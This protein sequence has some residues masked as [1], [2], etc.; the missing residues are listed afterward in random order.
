MMG[1]QALVSVA[2]NDHSVF[3]IEGP[4][5]NPY[6]FGNPVEGNL[7]LGREDVMR[8]LEE[9]LS[10]ARQSS[11]VIL[12]GHRRMGKS[13][14]LRNLGGRFGP[15][16]IIVDFNMQRVG[17]V[18]NTNELL[19]GLALKFYDA[20]CDSGHH[21]LAEPTEALFYDHNPYLAFDRFLGVL[22]RVRDRH[23]FIVTVDEFELIEQQINEQRV[24]MNLLAHWRGI[25]QTYPWLIMIFAGLHAL[26]EM[27][28]DYWSPL[29]GSVTAV[30]VSF[31][32]Y[33]AAWRLITQPAADFAIDYD[34]DV[35]DQIIALTNGQPYLVQ[36]I[37]HNL[38]TSFNRHLYEEGV[39]RDRRFTIHDLVA[40]INAPEFYR[41]GNAYFS[42]VWIQAATSQPNGQ[43]TVLQSLSDGPLSLTEIAIATGMSFDLVRA[44]L[45]TLQHHDVIVQRD[46][47]HSYAVELMRRWALQRQ[48]QEQTEHT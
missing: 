8:R 19:F 44:A 15:R 1:W 2:Y 43:T 7:F 30:D 34:A 27:R 48:Q 20:W 4:I 29:F 6:V 46:G 11:S 41:D 42:G 21:N 36:L 16:T 37:G 35:V 23:R 24:E 32:L 25:I 33:E 17:R 14:I 12:Y 5:R 18:R 47:R 28:Q 38:V 13:S 45:Y 10:E 39:S 26:E 40:V 22:D 9:L 3:V 31:L